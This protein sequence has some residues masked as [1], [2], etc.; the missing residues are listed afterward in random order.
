LLEKARALARDDARVLREVMTELAGAYDQTG[1]HEKAV[2]TR[3]Q[4]EYLPKGRGD[5]V[6]AT[7]LASTLPAGGF[8]GP[9]GS[10][11][12]WTRR[13]RWAVLGTVLVVVHIALFFGYRSYVAS[14]RPAVPEQT[15]TE[16]AQTDVP[17]PDET[18][19]TAAATTMHAPLVGPAGKPALDALVRENVGLLVVIGRY[20]GTVNGQPISLDLPIGTGTAFV[21][22]ESGILLTAKH[23]TGAARDPDLPASL[24][25]WRMP[26]VTRR[27]ISYIVCF[28][29][30]ARDQLPAKLLLESEKFDMAVLKV[31]RTFASPLRLS[32]RP[33]RLGDDVRVVGFPGVLQQAFNEMFATNSRLEQAAQ[34]LVASGHVNLIAEMFSPESFQPTATRGIIS[35]AERNFEGV[36]HTQLDARVAPGNSGGPL[37]DGALEVVGIVTLAGT[38]AEG[39]RESA[40]GYNFA[41]LV[42]QLRDELAQYLE[43]H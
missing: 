26:T 24:Q 3:E 43:G 34:K 5:Q 17:A 28:G 4:L 36:E 35:T 39:S 11:R 18:T 41:L 27:S 42:G 19:L 7:G 20:E 12:T 29:P 15:A 21:V 32:K 30:A 14:D 31:D 6:A 13:T 16:R 1:Q 33:P 40:E 23:V 22:R 25:D 10:A 8:S 38:K 37:L 9:P 2:R